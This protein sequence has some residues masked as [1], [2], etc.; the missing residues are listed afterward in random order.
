MDLV[1]EII[2]KKTTCVFV[3][4]HQD[5]AILS[6]G[7]LISQFSGKTTIIVV[8]VFTKAHKKPYTFSAKQFLK[9]SFAI[10]ANK[11]YAEREREDKNVLS[12]FSVKIVNLGFQD[13]L[14][15]KKK[16]SSLL[17][18]YM[19]EFDH[20][21]PT[22]RWHIIKG[23]SGNDY[24]IKELQEKLN[25]FKK[26]NILVFAPYGIGNHAD[27]LVTRKACEEMFD[28][29]L[30]YSDFPYNVRLQN[31]GKPFKNGNIYKIA[32]NMAK[33]SKLIKGYKTQFEGLFP[34]GTIPKHNEI[35]F[36]NKKV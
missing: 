8:N 35:Y 24:A 36:T 10:D 27:H 33:K 21:Y 28:N 25:L 12:A 3:S 26:K 30:F 17:G 29:L 4:P 11:L 31:F 34:D 15:R 9:N 32:P 18:K 16:N 7:E 20:I 14:F 22:Y 19:P 2:N 6:C 5:D 13:A 1:K 23:I